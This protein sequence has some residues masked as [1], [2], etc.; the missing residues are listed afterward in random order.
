MIKAILFYFKSF[1]K[2]SAYFY[3]F[4]FLFILLFYYE[5]LGLNFNTANGIEIY[6][7]WIDG[8]TD[9]VQYVKHLGLHYV[10]LILFGSISVMQIA[11]SFFSADYLGIVLPKNSNRN[12]IY[13]YFVSFLTLGIAL[14]FSV[15]VVLLNVVLYLITSSFFFIASLKT[16][17]FIIPLALFF[18]TSITAF[19]IISENKFANLI[20]VLCYLIFLP[21]AFEVII[22]ADYNTTAFINF[23]ALYNDYYIPFSGSFVSGVY[24]YSFGFEAFPEWRG[25]IIMSAV[26]FV[27]GISSFKRKIY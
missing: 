5:T 27:I 6:G 1:L 17:I 18:S 24:N 3:F 8:E 26:F 23:L 19:S 22:N 13:A 16:L 14:F 11:S 10:I 25:Y 9:I 2:K 4:G 12:F 7:L 15:H 20:F 21:V